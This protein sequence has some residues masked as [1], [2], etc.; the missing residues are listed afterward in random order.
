MSHEPLPPSR[1][2]LP[3]WLAGGTAAAYGVWGSAFGADTDPARVAVLVVGAALAHDLLLAP[4]V[5][6]VAWWGRHLLPAPAR[7]WAGG[8]L[9]VSG[10]LVAVAVPVI[11]RFGERADDPSLLPRDH[12]QGL[13][14]V[15]ALIWLVA[16]GGLWASTRDG[17]DVTDRS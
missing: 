11:G 6:A 8:A 12:G 1:L 10:A 17:D 14:V 16:A 4:V 9:L 7:R 3:L 2:R 5:V 15:L 13:L